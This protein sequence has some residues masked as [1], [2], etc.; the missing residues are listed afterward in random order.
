MDEPPK[1]PKK[2]G[3]NLTVAGV[4]FV[5]AYLYYVDVFCVVSSWP[6]Q[7]NVP[8]VNSN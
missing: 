8:L 5:F 2:R 1:T 7:L 3:I 6:A 4:L